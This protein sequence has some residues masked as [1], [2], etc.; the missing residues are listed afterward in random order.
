MQFVTTL[1]NAIVGGL[2][3]WF[4]LRRLPWKA[5]HA[6]ADSGVAPG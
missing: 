5:R 3:I 1:T 4:T 2:A 6:G